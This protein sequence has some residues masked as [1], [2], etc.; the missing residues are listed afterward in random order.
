LSLE[1]QECPRD[2]AL[3]EAK[4]RI[5]EKI[6]KL[7]EERNI[8][9]FPR[10]VYGRIPNFAGA[11]KAA[12]RTLQLREWEKAEVVKINPD[13][14]QAPLR[15]RVLEDRKLLVVPSPRLT[16]GFVLL[17]PRTIPETLIKTASRLHGALKLG[18]YITIR[19]LRQLERIDLIVEG[20]VAVNRWG[21][22]LGK[23]SGYGELEYAILAS[24]GLVGNHT[25]IVT[26]VHDVQVVN[27]RLPQDPWDVPIDFICTPTKTIQCERAS[28]RPRGLLWECLKGRE[29]E[30]PI[31][32]EL[33]KELS[34]Q[35]R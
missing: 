26:T 27:E 25:P 22:R 31:V 7:M 30:I 4:R 6:W 13:S 9:R 2:P 35:T 3:T 1:L 10:P 5:R 32:E 14:P 12:I 15:Q 17:D 16:S 28:K 34:K 21:E 24:L 20:S 18:K 11:E 19:E 8:A 33:R 23:G 29:R